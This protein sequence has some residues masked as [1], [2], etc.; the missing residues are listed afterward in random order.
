MQRKRRVRYTI[1]R[2]NEPASPYRYVSVGDDGE[3]GWGNEAAPIK[4]FRTPRSADWFRSYR[5]C[6]D[7]AHVVHHSV[8]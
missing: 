2:L 4:V 5:M 1:E 8:H 3:Y 7:D 6:P